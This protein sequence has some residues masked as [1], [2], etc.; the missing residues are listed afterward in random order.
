M[1]SAIFLS[2]IR[3]FL[4]SM[5]AG[6]Q[7]WGSWELRKRI[8]NREKTESECAAES[9]GIFCS[10]VYAI[11]CCHGSFTMFFA[12][13]IKKHPKTPLL[14]LKWNFS[15]V[16]N[17]PDMEKEIGSLA[18]LKSLMQYLD[19]LNK[20]LNKYKDKLKLASLLAECLWFKRK[21][22]GGKQKNWRIRPVEECTETL[23]A[24]TSCL[25]NS[26]LIV[27]Y[28]T[29]TVDLI[30]VRPEQFLAALRNRTT[31]FMAG[32]TI[33]ASRLHFTCELSL[34]V[35]SRGF[36]ICC[37]AVAPLLYLVLP[38]QA[39]FDKHVP[40]DNIAVKLSHFARCFLDFWELAASHQKNGVLA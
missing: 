12:C 9:R 28:V 26:L 5:Q 13:R 18:P 34:S 16:Q 37:R 25:H 10:K 23:E 6:K 36:T 15:K 8:K 3:T 20:V 24:I 31:H 17:N 21:T 19:K 22:T 33:L 29:G 2:L 27:Y 32:Y 38:T 4:S 39:D 30:L 40:F 7:H 35:F 11:Q 1:S 14:L